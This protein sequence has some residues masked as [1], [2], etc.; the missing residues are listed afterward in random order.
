MLSNYLPNR[1][2]Y[3][4]GIYGR[5]ILDLTKTVSPIQQYSNVDLH[6]IS[7]PRKSYVVQADRTDAKPASRYHMLAQRQGAVESEMDSTDLDQ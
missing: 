1:L 2:F 7:L 3:G 4:T 5:P 6:L